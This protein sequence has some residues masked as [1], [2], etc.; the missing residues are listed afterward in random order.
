MT[1]F[2]DGALGIDSAQKEKAAYESNGKAT[3][4]NINFM[5]LK[6]MLKNL[7]LDFEY[8]VVTLTRESLGAYIDSFTPVRTPRG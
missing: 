2:S 7:Y 5:T 1:E 4:G 3:N 6:A 8:F